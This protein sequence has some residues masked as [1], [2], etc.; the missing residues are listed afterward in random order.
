MFNTSPRPELSGSKP[1]TLNCRFRERIEIFTGSPS[2]VALASLIFGLYSGFVYFT[3][4]FGGI[5]ADRWIRTT[6][7]RGSRRA[8]DERRPYCNGF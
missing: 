6:Q 5:I 3:P 1:E 8:I 4:V 7:R 2:P